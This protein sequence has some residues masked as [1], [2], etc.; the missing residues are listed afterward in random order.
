[1]K[2][3][4]LGHSGSGKSTLARKLG[5]LYGL[6]VLHLDTLQFETNWIERDKDEARTMCREFM[7]NND[8]WVIDGNYTWQFQQERLD[9]A[10]LIVFMLFNRFSCIY[11]AS[12]QFRMYSGK[13]R[14]D[15]ARGCNEKLDHEFVSWI[16]FTSRTAEKQKKRQFLRQKYAMKM[17]IIKNQR[18]LDRFIKEAEALSPSGRLP[19]P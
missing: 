3:A 14:P 11:R 8:S 16:L 13:S 18:Q 6:P 5:E 1:M 7:D 9:N 15:M 12:K 10:D 2:I 4:I 17:R 19:E